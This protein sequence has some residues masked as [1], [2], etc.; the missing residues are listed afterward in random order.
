MLF[1]FNRPYKLGINYFSLNSFDDISK[2]IKHNEQMNC[3]VPVNFVEFIVTVN[4]D[5]CHICGMR[6]VHDIHRNSI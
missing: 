5:R 1:S 3:G 6:P 4:I 2:I